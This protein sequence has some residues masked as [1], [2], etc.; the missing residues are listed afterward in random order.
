MKI[1]AVIIML[2]A[3][4]CSDSNQKKEIM[5]DK[6][7]KNVK[8]KFL[9]NEKFQVII[10][11]AETEGSILIY[12]LN[13]NTYYSNDFE[14]ARVERLPASTFKIV[15]TLIGLETGVIDA[16]TT[17][18]KWDGGKRDLAVWEQDQTLKE[19]FHNSCVPCYQ[20]VAR[21]IGV[22]RMN[23]YLKKLEYGNMQI[24]EDEIAAF[25][26]TGDFGVSQFEQIEFLK[27]LEQNKLSVSNESQNELKEI[28]LS[29]DLHDITLRAKTGWAI[30]EGKN[31][32]WYVGYIEKERNAYFFAVNIRPKEKFDMSLFAKIRKDITFRALK[33]M[34]IIE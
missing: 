6:E 20:E 22:E 2:L 27:K 23:E 8:E 28:M 24:N 13:E 18:F 17:L 4:S 7:T 12:N 21:N 3:I 9:K 11:N 19:A 29:Y 33:E 1:I 10:D 25:W 31:N 34:G 30:R 26:L 15:N 5:Q 14:W 32:G 16:D